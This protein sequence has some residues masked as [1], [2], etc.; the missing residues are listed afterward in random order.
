VLR[1]A[2]N[3]IFYPLAST[4]LVVAVL[5]LAQ[6]VLVPVALALLLAFL[7]AP[8]VTQV[9]RLRI[10]R[11]ISVLVVTGLLGVLIAAV[12]WTLQ[13]QLSV[14]VEQLPA[15]RASLHTKLHALG[16]QIGAIQGL[17]N[18][19]STTLGEGAGGAG[20]A[21]SAAAPSPDT[22]AVQVQT[23]FGFGPILERGAAYAGAATGL[24]MRAGLVLVLAVFMLIGKEQ[25]R[26]KVLKLEFVRQ[27]GGSDA[28]D[29]AARRIGRYVIAQSAVNAIFGAAAALGL[30]TIHAT[31]GGRSTAATPIIAG[32]LSGLLRFIPF[33]GVWIGASI[34]LVFTFAAYPDNSVVLAVLLLYVVL[35]VVAGQWVEPNMLGASTGISPLAMLLAALFWTWVWGIVGLLLSTPLTVILLVASKHVQGLASLH[36]MLAAEENGRKA[37]APRQ[38][39]D[40]VLEETPSRNRTQDPS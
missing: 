24:A 26:A 14:I 34:P 37:R 40:C 18:E 3:S 36:I 6:G 25:W 8:A 1:P 7:L 19:F 2:G 28:L 4:V 11:M 31:I 17:A 38:R 13:R 27:A 30:W 35:E 21:G 33:V 29:E 12:I 5:Y 22:P 15:F 39:T 10:G 32:L 23:G 20:G 9:E 16:R